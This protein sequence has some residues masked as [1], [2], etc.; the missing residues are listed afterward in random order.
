M[1]QSYPTNISHYIWRVS[2]QIISKTPANNIPTFSVQQKL[3]KALGFCS[4][5][6]FD[7]RPHTPLLRQRQKIIPNRQI[8]DSQSHTF[9]DN[10]PTS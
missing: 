6:P 5:K 4:S 1:R 9:V 2:R 8:H 3:K 7:S 10:I